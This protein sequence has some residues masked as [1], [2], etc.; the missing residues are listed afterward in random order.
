MG[1]VLY[2]RGVFI[3]RCY[4]ELN[5]RDP[6]LIRDVHRAYVKAPNPGAYDYFGSGVALSMDGSTLAAKRTFA[7]ASA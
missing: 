7:E 1:T 4:D 5:L 3:N 2:S 6:D